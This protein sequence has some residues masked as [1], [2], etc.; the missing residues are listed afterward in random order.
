MN[1][2]SPYTPMLYSSFQTSMLADFKAFPKLTDSVSLFKALQRRSIP[3]RNEAALFSLV[4]VS[5]QFRNAPTLLAL[6]MKFFRRSWSISAKPWVC[7]TT[8]K[9]FM[10]NLKQNSSKSWASYL[11]AAERRA[12]AFSS[13]M[14][15]LI[16][17]WQ[18]FLNLFSLYSVAKSS[19]PMASSGG[20]LILSVYRY[21][22]KAR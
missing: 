18:S 20:S 14:P 16:V 9:W 22:R 2:G 21:S 8:V 4:V 5:S 6:L 13:Q 10:Q 3:R 15:C 17:C 11:T 12:I 19:R 7:V 1:A